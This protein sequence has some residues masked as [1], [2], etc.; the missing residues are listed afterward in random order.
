MSYAERFS[1]YFDREVAQKAAKSIND[2]AEMEF[3][4]ADEAF[5]FTKQGG[6]NTVKP[7]PARD[8]QLVF[9]LTPSAADAVL[10]D[11]SEDIG[12][13]GVHIAKMIAAPEGDKKVTWKLKAGFLTLWGKGYFGVLTSGGAQFA[14]FLASK[15]LNGIGAI[16]DILKKMKA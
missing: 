16:K 14:S 11:L 3:H 6:K 15:G 8:P 5:T 10:A 9:T 4:V 12:S 1:Q 7:G 13:I 2:G